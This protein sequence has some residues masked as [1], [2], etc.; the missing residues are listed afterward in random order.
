VQIKE[1]SVM[2]KRANT[3]RRSTRKI[4]SS[5]LRALVLAEAKKLQKESLSGKIASVED[6]KAKEEGWANGDALEQ[7]IDF[8][9]ALKIQENKLTKQHKNLVKKMKKLQERKAKLRKRIIKNI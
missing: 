5:A 9:K 4:S 8:I 6:V 2:K 7:D 1:I 3:R